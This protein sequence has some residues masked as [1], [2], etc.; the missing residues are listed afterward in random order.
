M[1]LKAIFSVL[2]R[3]FEFEL[4]QP[5]EHYR[6][7]ETR[8]VV[9]IEQPCR[10][11]Y[12]RRQVQAHVEAGH[13]GDVAPVAGAARLQL[14][15]DLCQGHGVCASECPELFSIDPDEL[16][17]V[18]QSDVVAEELRERAERAVRYCPTRALSITS[19]ED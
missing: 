13:S 6:N 11:R 4:A 18:L 15:R 17:V 10:V 2:L 3:E 5:S 19:E 12:R 14:D 1:Q 16:K 7:D 9:Q 8:M